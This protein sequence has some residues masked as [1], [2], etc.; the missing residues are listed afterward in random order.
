M[1]NPIK[2]YPGSDEAAVK[3]CTC[4]RIDNSYGAGRGG[5]GKRWGWYIQGD[6]FLHAD[7]PKDI[8]SMR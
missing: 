5:D 7:N 8:G 6:C 1:S 3:G 4:P 2:P